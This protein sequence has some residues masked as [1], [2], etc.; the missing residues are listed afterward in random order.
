MTVRRSLWERFLEAVLPPPFFPTSDA[1]R[2][3]AARRARSRADAEAARA[4]LGFDRVAVVEQRMEL[5]RRVAALDLPRRPRYLTDRFYRY[6]FRRRDGGGRTIA[7]ST[8]RDSDERN[9]QLA[10][11]EEERAVIAERAALRDCYVAMIARLDRTGRP[12]RIHVHGSGVPPTE[13][14]LLVPVDE[15][16]LP[17]SYTTPAEPPGPLESEP[18]PPPTSGALGEGILRSRIPSP[19]A[20]GTG[21]GGA[22]SASTAGRPSRAFQHAR[23]GAPDAP[24]IHGLED[25]S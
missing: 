1:Q 15:Q 24:A 8:G 13:P 17:W 5:E 18:Q 9:L 4:R 19:E 6:E 23:A 12:F 21:G 16:G 7:D 25:R 22:P 2:E 10:E 11:V 20:P 3:L 14:D